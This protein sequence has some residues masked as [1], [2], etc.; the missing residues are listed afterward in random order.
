[1]DPTVAGT[2]FAGPPESTR[3]TGHGAPPP[4]AATYRLPA[5]SPVR[6]S[7]ESVLFSTVV[8]VAVAGAVPG[9]P[10]PVADPIASPA[11]IA[12]AAAP[13]AILNPRVMTLLPPRS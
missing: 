2:W 1:M 11:T 6:P 12:A 5:S 13:A 7:I 8:Q 3:H 9:R 10:P 4:R